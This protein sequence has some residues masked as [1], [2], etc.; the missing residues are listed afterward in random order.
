MDMIGE[1]TG[2]IINIHNYQTVTDKDG[3]CPYNVHHIRK[4]CT[5]D[6]SDNI[7]GVGSDWMPRL[8][9]V[10]PASELSKLGDLNLC[11]KYIKETIAKYPTAPN[12]HML[13]PTFN[14]LVPLEVP[15]HL[16]NDAEPDINWDKLRY[17]VHDWN[18]QEDKWGFE[19]MLSEYIDHYYE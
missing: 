18:Y 2:K 8:D 5:S 9:S 15:E 17:F 4:M 11:R 7:P 1:K 16:L 10:I 19:D 3:W 12:A 14:I 6:R 13:L